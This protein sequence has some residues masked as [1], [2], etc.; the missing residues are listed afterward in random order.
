MTL[1]VAY[2]LELRWVSGGFIGVDIFFVISGFLITRLLLDE[3]STTGRLDVGAFWSRRFKRLVPALVVMIA[4]TLVATWRWGLPEQWNSVRLDAVAGLAYVANWRFVSD[5]QSYFEA[6]LGPSPLLHTWSL[7]VEE[8]WYLLWPIAM[9]GLLLLAA[10]N[11]RGTELAAAIVVAAGIVS[12]GLMAITFDPADP[13]R[14]YFGT[15]TR[16]QHLLIG[17]ALA[18]FVELSPDLVRVAQRRTMRLPFTAA[19]VVLVALAAT[20]HDTSAW[21]YQ[22]GLFA[23]S[24]VAAIVVLGTAS[25]DPDAALA[26]LGHQP[27]TWIGQRSY[28]IYLWHWPVIVFIG[29]GIDIGVSGTPLIMAQIAIT[30]AFAELSFRFVEAPARRSTTSSPRLVGAWSV[31]ACLVAGL[32]FVA[33]TT[34]PDRRLAP[35]AAIFPRLDELASPTREPADDAVI[36]KSDGGNVPTNSG[37]RRVLLLGDSAAY[38]LAHQLDVATRPDWDAQAYVQVGCPITPGETL[39]ADSSTTN[40]ID[41]DCVAW[42]TSWPEFGNALQPDI[43]VVMIGAWEV[44]DH[45]VDGRDI[46]FPSPEWEAL[47]A[48]ALSE[49]AAAAGSSGASVVLLD[50]AC[51]GGASNNPGTAARADARRVDAVNSL[52]DEVAATQPDVTVAPLSSVVC[53]GGG[54]GLTIDG[55]PV[56]YD[57]VHYTRKGAALVWPWLFDELDQRLSMSTDDP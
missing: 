14:S 28:G 1:V 33:L 48:T 9:V 8:Q 6:A 4:A 46:R 38:S 37:R 45:R 36:D 27:L 21:L 12:A 54:D 7:A 3:R 57:G 43:V 22:G 20:I 50:V 35:T 29:S 51:M 24:I 18:W 15:D 52:L 42:Q 16:A 13:S 53:P 55:S 26:W 2:H 34:P 47:V 10:R 32:G 49:A 56:R 30:L 41:P 17:A 25:P 31:G 19:L 40:P 39:A 23:I 11:R 5:Q 44:L